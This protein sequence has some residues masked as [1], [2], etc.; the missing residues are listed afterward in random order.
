MQVSIVPREA[1]P[2]V[3]REVVSLLSRS[4]AHAG[5]R[6]TLEDLTGEILNEQR[7]L[8]VV[9]GP[10][11]EQFEPVAVFTTVI[12]M[13]PS[14]RVLR[15]DFLAGENL[16]EWI[17]EAERVLLRY[18]VEQGCSALEMTGRRGWTPVLEKL[19]W[20]LAWV[21]LERPTPKTLFE[22]FNEDE[23]RKAV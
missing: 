8:W 11:R 12:G 14:K 21:T 1:L 3:V 9:F 2:I 10:E 20:K 7:Q 18:A 16:A 5:G 19:G 22:V 17:Q 15:V 6:M 13:Y 23:L 4:L